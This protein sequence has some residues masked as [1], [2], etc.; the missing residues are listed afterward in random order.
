MKIQF[1][2]G[3]AFQRRLVREA[4]QALNGRHFN[5]DRFTH[6]WQVQFLPPSSIDTT[7]HDAFKTFM[8][9][10]NDGT[11]QIRNDM[12]FKG[13]GP[14]AGTQFFQESVIHELGHHLLGNG[15]GLGRITD[16]NQQAIAA[17]FGSTP[18]TWNPQSKRWEDRPVEGIAETFKDCFLAASRRVYFNR[19]DKKLAISRYPEFRSHW[20]AG[21][22]VYHVPSSIGAAQTTGQATYE[23]FMAAAGIAEPIPPGDSSWFDPPQSFDYY[24]R[25]VAYPYASPVSGF[26]DF[27]EVGC[28]VSYGSVGAGGITPVGLT[29]G[30]W[31]VAFIPLALVTTSGHPGG[32]TGIFEQEGVFF[33]PITGEFLVEFKLWPIWGVDGGGLIAGHPFLITEDVSTYTSPGPILTEGDLGFL[34]FEYQPVEIDFHS[35][36]PDPDFPASQR[37]F[38]RQISVPVPSGALTLAGWLVGGRTT[39]EMHGGYP[40]DPPLNWGTFFNWEEVRFLVYNHQWPD[41]LALKITAADLPAF[42]EAAPPGKIAPVSFDSGVID[43]LRPIS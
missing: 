18:S 4:V 23:Q 16:A 28:Q 36:T 42:P 5:L 29:E 39:Q 13:K 43:H 32:S 25:Y 21:Q 40:V 34:H 1:S 6:T 37:K 14:F 2:G 9:T 22:K 11:T 20:R 24:G 26:N 27:G 19:T 7:P 10:Q 35:G 33:Y 17:M 41:Q 3:S 38:Q 15:P 30:V 31:D 8:V 12:P